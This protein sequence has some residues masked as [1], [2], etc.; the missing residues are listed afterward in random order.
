MNELAWHIRLIWKQNFQL[1]CKQ[2]KKAESRENL[3]V[4]VRM[5][6]FKDSERPRNHNAFFQTRFQGTCTMES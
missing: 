3:I 5:T 4:I 6:S 1:T 2:I